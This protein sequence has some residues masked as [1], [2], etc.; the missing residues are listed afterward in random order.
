MDEIIQAVFALGI[1][2]A[3][4]VLAVIGAA[5]RSY[6][7]K[8]LDAIETRT[9]IEI[10]EA[11]RK[12]LDDAIVNAVALAEERV[13]RVTPDEVIGYLRNFNPETLRH[14]PQLAS[15]EAL[16]KRVA[17]TMARTG[18]LTRVAPEPGATVLGSPWP[19]ALLAM[20]LF[21]LAA[22]EPVRTGAAMTAYPMVDRYCAMT[23][24]AAREVIRAS[25]GTTGAGNRIL[26]DCTGGPAIARHED[27]SV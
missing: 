22:C 10:D 6:V 11:R 17:A 16:R 27:S 26:I 9:G 3:L 15:T 12:A 8:A 25:F 7:A 14:F 1:T 20:L 24:A 4:G 13:G 19:V 21:G 23:P 5:V 2:I 18:T